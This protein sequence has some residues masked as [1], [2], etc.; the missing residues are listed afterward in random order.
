M[1]SVVW[2]SS[3][4]GTHVQPP[5]HDTLA[6]PTADKQQ[7]QGNGHSFRVRHLAVMEE[8]GQYARVLVR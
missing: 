7:P 8:H 2:P 6:L 5:S 4:V 3:L 1:R